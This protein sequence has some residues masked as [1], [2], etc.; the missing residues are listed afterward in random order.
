MSV[1]HFVGHYQIQKMVKQVLDDLRYV[2]NLVLLVLL[3]PELMILAYESAMEKIEVY[4]QFS[5]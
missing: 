4:Q 3:F 2:L 1:M 5:H